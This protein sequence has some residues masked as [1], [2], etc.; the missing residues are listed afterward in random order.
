[1]DDTWEDMYEERNVD[2]ARKWRVR[3]HRLFHQGFKDGIDGG[4]QE[5]V[6]DGFNE[7]YQ[8]GITVGKRFG[9]VEGALRVA[10]AYAPGDAAQV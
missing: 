8:A 10:A 6:Q 4:M 1:M 2:F 5:Q 7:V 3:Y 9:F